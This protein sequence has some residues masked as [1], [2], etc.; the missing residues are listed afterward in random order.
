LT[1]EA[2]GRVRVAFTYSLEHVEALKRAVPHQDRAWHEDGN[3]Q[4]R[5]SQ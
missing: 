4:E 5:R 3:G 1:L 2:D